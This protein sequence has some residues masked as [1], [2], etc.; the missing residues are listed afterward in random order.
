MLYSI[1]FI[2]A[3]LCSLLL[4]IVIL[5]QSSKGGGLSS[6][7]GGA[8][9]SG[10]AFGTRQAANALHKLTINLIAGF[11]VLSLVATVL[12]RNTTGSSQIVTREALEEQKLNS[13]FSESIPAL[14]LPPPTQSGE[15]AAPAGDDAEGE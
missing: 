13:G 3:V 2:L 11:M 8:G 7:F 6:A 15:T 5:M 1:V 9:D 14:E 10:A 4:G 12:S